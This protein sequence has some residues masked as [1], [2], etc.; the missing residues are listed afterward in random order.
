MEKSKG[1]K[2]AKKMRVPLDT[3][4]LVRDT[5][6]GTRQRTLECFTLIAAFQRKVK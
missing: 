2:E 6:S 4:G 5:A 3:G 1:F